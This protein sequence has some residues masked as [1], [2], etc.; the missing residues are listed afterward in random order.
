M[1]SKEVGYS[2]TLVASSPTFFFQ[3]IKLTQLKINSTTSIK[4]V[5]S[6]SIEIC[7]FLREFS[8]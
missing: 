1:S 8:F 6:F 4:V 5:L 7:N 3:I 2:N